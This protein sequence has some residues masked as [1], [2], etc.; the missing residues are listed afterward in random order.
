MAAM[1]SLPAEIFG[2]RPR[3]IAPG[4]RADVVIW[5]GDPLEVTSA[6]DQ[7]IINGKLDP[8]TSRQTQLLERY[9]PTDPGLGRAY[10]S[11]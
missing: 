5:S 10:I 4:L 8:M 6:A 9:L 2:G 1:T 11:P 7:V 3:M